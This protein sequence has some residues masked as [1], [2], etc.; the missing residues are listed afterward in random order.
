MPWLSFPM[1]GAAFRRTMK[2]FV[3]SIVQ[4]SDLQ[5]A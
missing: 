2:A 5:A 4:E 3:P 1:I